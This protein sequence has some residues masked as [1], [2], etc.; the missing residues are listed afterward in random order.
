MKLL[1]NVTL[2]RPAYSGVCD[3]LIDSQ[4]ILAIDSSIDINCSALD[5]EIIDAK[6]KIACPGFIDSHFHILGGGGEN[7]Y[8]NRTP[9]VQLSQLTTAGVTTV[10]GLLGTD[11]VCRDDMALLAKARALDIEGIATYIYVGNYRLPVKTI[12]SSI[13]QDLMA[14]D[15]VI[16]IGEIAISDHRNGAPTFEQFA[17]AAAD[18]RTGGLLSGKAGLVNCHVGPNEGKLEFLFRAIKE[19]D[20]PITNFLPTHCGRSQGLVDQAI[21]FAKQGGTFDITA[22]EDPE[23]AEKL[24]G[25]IPFRR[26]LRQVLDEGL[27]TECVTLS[28]DGQGSLPRFDESGKFLGIGIGSAKSLLIGLQEAVLKEGIPLEQVL[29]TLT[30]NVA[31]IL[32]F[33]HKGSLEIGKDADILLLDP[34]DLSIDTVIAR[35]QMMVQNGEVKV[36]GAFERA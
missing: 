9:E 7:G 19:T 30:S 31:R 33:P 23:M 32:N 28:S 27:T 35:G 13:I 5:I 17:H 25:E 26:I 29:P 34:T 21:A 16:G 1:K 11:G 36:Y 20:I 15:K 6:G 4:R 3:L 14:I 22:S 24:T 2:Y 12:T 10:C 18:A 8:Q